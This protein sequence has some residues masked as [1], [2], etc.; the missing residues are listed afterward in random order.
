MINIKW[1]FYWWKNVLAPSQTKFHMYVPWH[2]LQTNL[3]MYV[4]GIV[5]DSDIW[6]EHTHIRKFVCCEVAVA[7][8]TRP[9]VSYNLC[10]HWF[11]FWFIGVETSFDSY[12]LNL[13]RFLYPL[14]WFTDPRTSIYS[15]V[16]SLCIVVSCPLDM[17]CLALLMYVFLLQKPRYRM[18]ESTFCTGICQCKCVFFY[19]TPER[20]II[21]MF[22]HWYICRKVSDSLLV[23]RGSGRSRKYCF[24]MSATS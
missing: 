6:G 9:L 21:C 17:K 22:L 20:W 7:L 1:K 11:T 2:H 10:W 15:I 3:W 4:F 5:Q 18:F 24:S 14:E 19:K 16:Q 12:F 13:F 8:H 23:S